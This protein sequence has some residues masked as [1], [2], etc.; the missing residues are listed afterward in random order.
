VSHPVPG[1]D[2]DAFVRLCETTLRRPALV[3][4]DG[5]VVAIFLPELTAAEQDVYDD[6]LRLH[7]SRLGLTP[8]EFLGLKDDLAGLRTY[9][10]LASP[11]AAQTAA[12]TKALI[13]VLRA[14]LD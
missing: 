2:R 12:A 8:S 13:R 5:Q 4:E 9:H 11:T 7:R 1:R 14:I 3:I 6:L 10:G